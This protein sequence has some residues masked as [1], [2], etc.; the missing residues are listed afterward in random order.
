VRIVSSVLTPAARCAEDYAPGRL[1]SPTGFDHTTSCVRTFFEK[2][3]LPRR[4]CR[5]LCLIFQL[6]LKGG[7]GNHSFITGAMMVI[8]G[9]VL[10]R[11]SRI[12]RSW[13]CPW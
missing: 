6:P 11:V 2:A 13:G 8:E 12:F 10:H 1:S 3:W 4:C 9:R 5:S 7:E